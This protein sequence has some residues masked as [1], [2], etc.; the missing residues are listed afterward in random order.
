MKIGVMNTNVGTVN[1][2]MNVNEIHQGDWIDLMKQ[3]D[4]ESIDFCMTSPPYWGLRDYGVEG[5]LGLEEHPNEYIKKLVKGFAILKKKTKKTGSFY[6]NLG[7]TYFGSP[8]GNPEHLSLTLDNSPEYSKDRW[9]GIDKKPFRSGEPDPKLPQRLRA[10]EQCKK[11]KSNWLQPKQLM[12]MPSRVAIALQEDGWILRNDIIWHKPNPMP[13]SVK[14]RLN[15]SYEHLFHF[16][17]SKKYYYDLDA[18][19]EPHKNSSLERAKRKDLT[20]H[21]QYRIQSNRNG[22][23]GRVH[24]L[25]KNPND[26]FNKCWQG[27]QTDKYGNDD[28]TTRRSRL[29][30]GLRAKGSVYHKDGKNPADFFSITTQPFS[31]AHF[32]VYPVKLCEKPI[33]SS[34]PN[35]ICSECGMARERIVELGKVIM[36]GGSDNGKMAQNKGNYTMAETRC[37]KLEQHEHKTIGWTKCNCNAEFKGAVALDPFCGA[38]TT[39]VALKKFKPKAKFIGFELKKEYIDMAYLRVGKRLSTGALLKYTNT[40]S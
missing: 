26:V 23:H 6:L 16:V 29:T 35:E 32:A 3:L 38:G 27:E 30:A 37:K 13:S 9:K 1:S 25:G 4:D 39:W 12:L 34:V 10:R 19:R 21:T 11:I 18:I 22:E 15:T 5:Q 36:T 17:K 8:C 31:K 28:E 2:M 24:P 20:Q 40:L 14:D 7:D 33:K